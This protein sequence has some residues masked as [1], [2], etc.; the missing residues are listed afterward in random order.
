M[1]SMAFKNRRSIVA[2]ML[3][4]SFLLKLSVYFNGLQFSTYENVTIFANLFVL[5]TG[6]FF[7]I[8]LFKSNQK[9]ATSFFD[10]F[11]AGM[12]VA[13]IYALLIS[14]F[15]YVYYSY[16]DSSYFDI[17]IQTQIESMQNLDQIDKDNAREMLDLIYSPYIWSTSSLLGYL[18]LGSFYSAIIAFLVRKF[19]GFRHD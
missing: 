14:V 3:A 5:M 7:G 2:S 19:S 4:I 18:F 10:D 16:I 17:R 15:F 11:K 8:R 13:S 12:R 9:E 6:V 1:A